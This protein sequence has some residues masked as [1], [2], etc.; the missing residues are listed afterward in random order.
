MEKVEAKERMIQREDNGNQ[1][2]NQRGNNEKE[3]REMLSLL[4]HLAYCEPFEI[5][6]LKRRAAMLLERMK[7]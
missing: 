1:R 3:Q 4:R 6:G 7:K 2:E 5:D